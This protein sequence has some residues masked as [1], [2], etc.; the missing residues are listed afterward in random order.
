MYKIYKIGYYNIKSSI[1]GNNMSRYFIDLELDI[2]SKDWLEHDKDSYSDINFSIKAKDTRK[3]PPCIA[4]YRLEGELD[5]LK[6]FLA[7]EYNPGEIGTENK[8]L[9][10]L[11]NSITEIKQ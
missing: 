8:E 10:S 11:Y 6:E 4:E 9:L 3:K 7:Y 5:D 2:E 1:V